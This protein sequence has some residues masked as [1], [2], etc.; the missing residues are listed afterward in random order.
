M[1]IVKI[2]N[3]FTT[4]TEVTDYF[5]FVRWGRNRTCCHCHHPNSSKRYA[6]FRY[7]CNHCRRKFSVTTNTYLHSTNLPLRTWLFSF[8][9]VTD[10]KKGISALQL[11]RNIGV[12]YDTAWNMY[13]QVREIMCDGAIKLEGIVEMDET[14]VGGKPRK[15]QSAK[16]TGAMKYNDYLEDKLDDLSNRFIFDTNPPKKNG[17]TENAP[18]GRGT[19]KIPVVGIV[20]RNGDVV[21]EVMLKTNWKNFKAMVQKYVDMDDSVLMT[22]QFKAYDKFDTII[23]HIKIDHSKMYSYKGLNTNS[24]ESFWAI[25]KRG[26]MGQYH[27][28]SEKYLPNYID[29]FCFK[30]NNR[31]FDDMFETLVFNSMMS[32]ETIIK[33]MQANSKKIRDG[34]QRARDIT[35]KQK[36]AKKVA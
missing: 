19:A 36:T 16:Y 11:Q 1:N 4:E 34:K 15:F 10:A 25:V 13:H 7:Y 28:V 30:Y 27:S 9:L 24:I 33:A 29:E 21:A 12:T 20:Q 17:L 23:E 2:A 6:D 22:D 32:P 14:Y 5:E 31:K 8:A 26:I 18:R 35:P 3:T